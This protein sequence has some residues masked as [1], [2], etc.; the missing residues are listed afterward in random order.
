MQQPQENNNI[1][2]LNVLT[3][4]ET[5]EIRTFEGAYWRTSLSAF[6]FALI[7]L[8]IFE[9]S[10]YRIGMVFVVYGAI[11]L[12][13]SL[14]KR[15]NTSYII[16][17]EKPFV[18]SG[19]VLTSNSPFTHVASRDYTITMAAFDSKLKDDKRT[20]VLMTRN[21]STK[22]VL[23][24][25]IPGI[26]QQILNQTIFSGNG[27]S[28]GQTII[29]EHFQ[30]NILPNDSN[31]MSS[32]S[33]VDGKT[34]NKNGSGDESGS[35]DKN[36]NGGNDVEEI[37]GEKK[38]VKKRKTNSGN[39]KVTIEDNDTNS[40]SKTNEE[41]NEAGLPKS[42]KPSNDKSPNN[43]EKKVKNVD[44]INGEKKQVK[45]RKTN[46]GNKKVTIEDND[47]NSNSKTNEEKNEAGL[48]KSPKPSNDKSP[49]NQE[50]KVKNV[51]GRLKENGK[52]FDSNTTGRPFFFTLGKAEVIKGWEIGINGMCVGGER[53]LVI[54]PALAYGTKGHPPTIP[55]G[56]TLEFEVKLLKVD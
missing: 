15:N 2:S 43:Q 21:D 31:I 20:S 48:P 29:D 42:P 18:T 41:K 39:K 51:D 32:T 52:V 25:L 13:I 14:F 26:E 11:L 44:E 17:K 45:K 4:A 9:D 6:G 24:N 53:K 28:S 22:Y 7:I 5:V 10:F 27:P 47:T 30:P 19:L 37:N 55:K 38:Q 23:C 50:K 49:N 46:S 36:E 56:A 3:E 35:N 16:D 33:K 40:N 12:C 34:K 1:E 54:P 8:R